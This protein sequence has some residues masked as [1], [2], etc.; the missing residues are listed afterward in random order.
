VREL[1]NQLA[2]ALQ[3]VSSAD[4]EELQQSIDHLAAQFHTLAE[5]QRAIVNRLPAGRQ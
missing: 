4:M 1:E 2:A 5:D 3:A